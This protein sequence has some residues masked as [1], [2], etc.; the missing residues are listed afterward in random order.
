MQ[1]LYYLLLLALLF[2]LGCQWQMKP[3]EE[4]KLLDGISVERFDRVE[5]GYLTMAD[6]AA[7]HQ[8]KTDYPTETRTLIE[9]VLQLGPA[10]DPEINSRLLVFF[11]DSTLQKLVADVEKQ[12]A[13][14][15]DVNW[16][17]TQAFRRL[18]QLMPDIE[19]PQVYA[20]I[21]SLDQSIVVAGDRLGISLDKYLGSDY[22]IYL[23]YG[24]T[25]QQRK[26]MKREYIVPDCVGFY[27]LSLFPMPDEE[28]LPTRDL[29]HWHISKIQWVVNQA[30]NRHVFSSDTISRL[31]KFKRANPR[32]SVTEL[33]RLTPDALAEVQ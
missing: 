15:D 7:L 6:I 1:K 27:L 12:Y 24:Y 21:G 29:G 3:S 5:S 30:M 26:M 31:D 11:Q 17:L 16:Q 22:P 25:E 9:D 23:R 20:Q 13:D 32:L 2:C 8:M 18:R 19:I 4:E 33:M 14:M 10:N 28:G